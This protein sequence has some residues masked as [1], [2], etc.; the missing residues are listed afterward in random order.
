MGK[1][2][3]LLNRSNRVALSCQISRL[4]GAKTKLRMATQMRVRLS[5]EVH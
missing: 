3:F 5:I 1:L 2:R 4:R